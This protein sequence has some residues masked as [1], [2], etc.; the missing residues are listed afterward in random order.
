MSRRCRGSQLRRGIH[1]CVVLQGSCSNSIA[2]LGSLI[3]KDANG[4]R[5]GG[6]WI[7]QFRRSVTLSPVGMNEHRCQGTPTSTLIG[8]KPP[9]KWFASATDGLALCSGWISRLL[10]AGA[11]ALMDMAFRTLALSTLIS[12][13]LARFDLSAY[14]LRLSSYWRHLLPRQPRSLEIL[15]SQ[16]ARFDAQSLRL[17]VQI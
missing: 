16:S 9:E 1:H 8:G 13:S 14:G 6:S 10:A 11:N 5:G 3:K 12:S 4:S 2:T 15:R 17:G 7:L